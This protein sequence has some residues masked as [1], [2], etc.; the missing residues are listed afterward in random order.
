MLQWLVLAS[1]PRPKTANQSLLESCTLSDGF[2]AIVKIFLLKYEEMSAWPEMLLFIFDFGT[3]AMSKT[4][5]RKE[6]KK[7]TYSVI[8]VKYKSSKVRIM[9]E[10]FG[11]APCILSSQSVLSSWVVLKQDLHGEAYGTN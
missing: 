7:I 1:P 2:H 3:F 4:L 11:N 8:H 9:L 6:K 10:H 5:C